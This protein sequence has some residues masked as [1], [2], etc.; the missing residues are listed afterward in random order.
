M[1]RT[2]FSTYKPAVA[3]GL[4][5]NPLV[6]GVDYCS[7]RTTDWTNDGSMDFRLPTMAQELCAG[8]DGSAPLF[9]CGS[10]AP[11]RK[12]AILYVGSGPSGSLLRAQEGRTASPCSL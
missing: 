5:F 2:R 6:F 7:C 12:Y 1:I 4:R 8:Q 10:L 9:A 3:A 11:S